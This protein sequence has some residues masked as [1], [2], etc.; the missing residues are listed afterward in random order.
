MA[1]S[2]RKQDSSYHS[3]EIGEMVRETLLEQYVRNQEPEEKTWEEL[4]REEADKTV[5]EALRRKREQAKRL[6]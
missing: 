4:A 6:P 2:L 1:E 5:E 3:S